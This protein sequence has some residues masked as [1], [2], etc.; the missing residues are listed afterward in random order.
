MILNKRIIREF[1]ENITKY[2]GLI[3]LIT[4][5]SMA[6]VAFSNSADCVIQ[7]GTQIAKTNNLEDGEFEVKYKLDN[8]T[9]Q[10]INDSGVTINENFYIDYSIDND[11]TLRLFKERKNLNKITIVNGHNFS[12]DT[13]T[14]I[15]LDEHFASANNYTINSKLKLNNYNFTI[16]GYAAA[17]D[18]SLVIKK[19]TDSIASPN[20]F[21]IGF[22]SSDSFNEFNNNITYS[23]SYKLNGFS[24]EKLKNI[25]S[26]NSS[27]ISFVD[28]KDNQ[29][30]SGY[31]DDN[32]INKNV[33]MSLGFVLI[34]MISF[35]I[36]VSIINT[37]DKESPIIGTLYSLGYI[38][39]ELLSHFIILPI[40]LVSIGSISGT[41]LGFLL[42]RPLIVTST[43]YYSLPYIPTVYTP[44]LLVVGILVPIVIVVIVNTYILSKRLNSSPLQLLRNEKKQSKI[45]A[46]NITRFKFITK[47]RL[48]QFLREYTSN[49]I[50]LFGIIIS[51]FLL[52]F[53]L[54][55]NRAIE[56]YL[57]NIADE[58]KFQYTYILNLPIEI[59]ENTE[60]EKTTITSLSIYYE[61][62]GQNIDLTFQG[63]KE[64]S[65]FYD[66]NIKNS[67]SGIYIS[68]NVHNK[69]GLDIGD[70][71]HLKDTS[72]N[73]IYN[74][75]VTGIFNYSTGLY[76]FM[77]NEQL[78]LLIGESKNYFNSYLSNKKLNIDDKYITSLIT[79]QSIIESG[80]NM[81]SSMTEI[82]VLI[83]VFASI[84]FIITMYL[85]LKL[86]IDKNTYS[87]S[88]VKVLGYTSK[89]INKLYLGSS[90]YV[91]LT[92]AL[93][94][95]PL[96]TKIVEILWP[97]LISNMQT[98]IPIVLKLQD[99]AFMFVIIFSSY[100]ISLYFL[101]KHLYSISMTEALKNRD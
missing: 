74:L 35:I 54:G 55:T 51:T 94:A 80:E 27:L 77:N 17:P 61:T 4:L 11:K 7:T 97:N 18:Y 81:T 20:N 89:E 36:S 12:S 83:I 63:I 96:C 76:V 62:L 16:V 79:N 38:R 24:S 37:I 75:K 32:I 48:R 1:K 6:I 13:A 23:Y 88:L 92:S 46:I 41:F 29:R 72:K 65:E 67:D 25:I 91:V 47:F 9:L 31:I 98:Y 85:L 34:I 68:S 87:I 22:I 49:L 59:S 71:I 95:I 5:S 73:K 14:E 78:N 8:F 2:I 44:S 56:M 82:I 3:L 57:Q 15:V 45:S 43:E 53:G 99:Y 10:K 86:M 42:A 70:T 66:F 19:L 33:G 26:K 39:K 100:Y 84:M 60:V 93:I 69:F 58:N 64:N 30:I 52:I 90:F 50:L 28:A 101:K 40:I 21:G